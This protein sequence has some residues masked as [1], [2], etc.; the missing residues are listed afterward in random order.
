MGRSLL[1]RP[2][3]LPRI[4]AERLFWLE[5]DI[6]LLV[7]EPL[8]ADRLVPLHCAQTGAGP[9]SSPRTGRSMQFQAFDRDATV[10]W[11]LFR[12]P[13]RVDALAGAAIEL[14]GQ[15]AT[16]RLAAQFRISNDARFAI[17]A[18]VAAGWIIDS[19]ESAPPGGVADW[20]AEPRRNG[21][22][23]LAIQLATGL[24]P[25]QPLRLAIVAR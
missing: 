7:P 19:V 17:G 14:D 20:S 21:G 5:G 22:Q 15:Q 16:A 24:S 2:W 1:D 6:S 23:R 13:A 25:R 11:L 10:E 9:L 4:R 18:D 12:P 8:L 3:R